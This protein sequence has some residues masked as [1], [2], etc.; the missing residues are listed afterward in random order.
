M[1]L[2][3]LAKQFYA[4]IRTRSKS[5]IES[6]IIK[7]DHSVREMLTRKTEKVDDLLP[8]NRKVTSNSN[9]VLGLPSSS[10]QRSNSALLRLRDADIPKRIFSQDDMNV[11]TSRSKNK[12]E[13]PILEEDDSH[14]KTTPVKQSDASCSVMERKMSQTLT[15]LTSEENSQRKFPLPFKVATLMKNSSGT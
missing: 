8:E 12:T 9:F 3:Q 11:L 13:M 6:K 14:V 4:D 15:R 7:K 2:K 10:I 5:P 1:R